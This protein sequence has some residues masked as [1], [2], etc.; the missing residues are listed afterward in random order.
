MSADYRLRN[1]ISG[2]DNFSVGT[3]FDG[4]WSL[5]IGKHGVV[6]MSYTRKLE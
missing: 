2:E 1:D 5:T 4:R 6:G 3:V